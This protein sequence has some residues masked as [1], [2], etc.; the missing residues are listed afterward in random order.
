MWLNTL[1]EVLFGDEESDSR[2]S[3][4]CVAS[5]ALDV[6]DECLGSVETIVISRLYIIMRLI[7][8]I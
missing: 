8:K 1:F 4:G 6:G 5:D 7:H 3:V 2:D